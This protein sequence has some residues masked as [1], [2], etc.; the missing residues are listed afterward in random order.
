MAVKY[1]T[2]AVVSATDRSY[3]TPEIINQRARTLAALKLRPGERVL[4]LGCGPGLLARELGDAVGQ[5]GTVLGIDSSAKM[6]RVAQA[7][8]D[9]L[10]Q[11]AFTTGS[12]EQSLADHYGV[13]DAA[14]CVQLLLYLSNVAGAI[15]EMQQVLKPGGRVAIIETDWRSVVLNSADNDF[16]K[17]MFHAWDAAVPSPNLPARIPALLKEHGFSGVR[18]EAIPIVCLNPTPDTFVG[19]VLEWT[20]RNARDRGAVSEDEATAWLSELRELGQTGGFFFCVNR[21]LFTGVRPVGAGPS[22][23]L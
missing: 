18:A 9:G 17:R 4:D 1:D 11:V 23:L 15:G 3:R 21:F 7:R 6:L 2:E 5:D 22:S 14:V 20:A 12:A 13:F 8:C 19:A 10:P 16:S